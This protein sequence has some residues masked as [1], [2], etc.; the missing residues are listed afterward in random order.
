MLDAQTKS[1][2]DSARDI[3]VGKVPDP[4]SQ[5]E[6][7][8]IALIYKFMDDMDRQ[9]EELGGK[10]T[11]FTGDFKKYRWANLLDKRLGGHE[12]LL[13]YAE[14]IEK[15]NENKNIPQLFRDIFK[16]VFLPYRDPETLNLFL[17][18]INGFSYDHSERL[19]DAFEYLL[20]VL[21]TQGDAGQFRTPRHVIAFIVAVVDPKKHETVL[22]PACG[23]AGFLISAFKHILRNNENLT[24]D[25]RA[26]LMTNFR[27]Y[28]IAPDMVRLSRAN[29]YLHGFP[30]PVI[31]EYDTLTS[32]ERWDERCDVILANPPFMSPTGGIRPHNRFSIKAKRSE[33]LFV[34]YMAEH[35]NSGGRAG[36]IVPEGIIFQ[37]QN[38][39]KAL[40]KML[41][42]NYLWAVVSLPAGVFNPYA[43]VK[44]CILFLDRNLARRTDELLFVKVESDGFDLGAQRRPNGKNDLP[45]ALEILDSHKKAQKT[46]ERKMALTV[47][48]KRLLDSG[49]INLSGDRYRETTAVQSKWPMVKLGEVCV[50]DPPKAEVRHLP[51]EIEVSFVPMAALEEHTVNI[52][53]PEVRK[54]GDVLKGYTYFRNGDVLLAKITPCFQNGK[55]V[56]ANNLL[57]GIGFGTTE[58]IVIRPKTDKLLP[59]LVYYCVTRPAFVRRGMESMTGSAGQ[60]RVPT[61]SVS[62]A[63]IPL[64]PLE[65][66]ERIVAE[67][68]GYRKI[69]EGARQVLANYKPTI[70]I[71]PEWPRVELSDIVMMKRGPFGGSLKKEIFVQTGYKVYEQKHAIQKDISIGTYFI[72]KQKFD[73]MQEFAVAPGDIIISCSGTM[74]RVYILPLDAPKGVINQALLKVTIDRDKTLA[75]YVELILSSEEVQSRYFRDTSG[76]AIQNVASMKEMR[77]IPIPLPP[78]SIQRR[79][80]AEIEAERALVEA[81]RKLIEVFEKKVQAK[82]AEVWGEE[83]TDAA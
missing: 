62:V 23:T 49:D 61:N 38:A 69:I 8:T 32:E 33:V 39:Y 55:C 9:S 50:I 66:Q 36:I 1:R 26:R 30:N 27:G 71:D 42:E 43:G 64:P 83:A 68:D 40:R 24:P 19:G 79:I 57:N 28:D 34:D 22:D 53:A 76:A 17:K 44:T 15:M 81:N 20:S 12:R 82:L 80:V 74:G 63:E 5:V 72:S 3:L 4:K 78:L 37:S 21:G 11:F 56:I 52:H 51:P 77:A 41:V 46:Q 60:Q 13:L 2:I 14:G 67:L 48:R 59:E 35:L 18:E 47:S 7:I 45:E 73:E 70:K 65:E 10:A 6:Q 31:H 16:G 58:F 54:L 75:K 25:E 29:L